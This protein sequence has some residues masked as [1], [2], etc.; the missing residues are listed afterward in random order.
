MT[1]HDTERMQALEELQEEALTD[2]SEEGSRI[3]ICQGEPACQLTGEEAMEH[4]I[5][6]CP[7]CEVYV[8]TD[9]ANGIWELIPP[10]TKH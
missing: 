3:I 8:L 9:A 7:Y 10:Q 4:Q 1:M 5:H 2:G 6:G